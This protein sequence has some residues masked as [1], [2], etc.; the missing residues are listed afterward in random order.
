MQLLTR[1]NATVNINHLYEAPYLQQTTVF[2][3]K[4]QNPKTSL[5]CDNHVG[6]ATNLVPAHS[7]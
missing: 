4:S 2:V 7:V 3:S 5:T 6:Y 1:S